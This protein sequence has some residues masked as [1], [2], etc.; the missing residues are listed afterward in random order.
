MD[1]INYTVQ[2]ELT[3]NNQSIGPSPNDIQDNYEHFNTQSPKKIT[4]TE[5]DDPWYNNVKF[6]NKSKGSTKSKKN[7]QKSTISAHSPSNNKITKYFNS[8]VLVC[9]LL[10]TVCTLVVTRRIRR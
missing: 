4:L 7:Q 5:S 9:C 8:D 6:R 3:Y 2:G 1:N 10:L